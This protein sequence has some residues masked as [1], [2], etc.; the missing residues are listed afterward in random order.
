MLLSGKGR[1]FDSERLSGKMC[2]GFCG[3]CETFSKVAIRTLVRIATRFP[4]ENLKLLLEAAPLVR[5]KPVRSF[6]GG[7]GIAGRLAPPKKA[8]ASVLVKRGGTAWDQA[9]AAVPG[10]GRLRLGSR[11]ARGFF[12]INTASR[13]ALWRMRSILQSCNSNASENSNSGG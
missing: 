2:C 11:R 5:L 4:L 6:L 9:N 1:K 8:R 7:G 12:L 13:G 10:N 3:E